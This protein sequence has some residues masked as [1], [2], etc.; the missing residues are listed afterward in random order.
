MKLSKNGI[1]QMVRF[2]LVGCCNT[3][4][5]YGVF[6]LMIAAVNLHKSVAQVIATGVA[7]CVSF[8]LNRKWTFQKDGAGNLTEVARFIVVNTISMLV[9]I[10]FTHLFYDILHIET[11]ANPFLSAIGISFAFEGDYAVMLAKL[12]ASVFSV[13]VNFIGNKFWVFRTRKEEKS[14]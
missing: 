2:G 3:L 8:L 14:A 5:D 10:V 6:Y 7:M 13:L 11:I 4:V 12:V 1:L 9:V